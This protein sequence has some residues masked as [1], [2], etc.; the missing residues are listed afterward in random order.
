MVQVLSVYEYE[1]YKDV[2]TARQIMSWTDTASALVD[3][4]VWPQCSLRRPHKPFTSCYK[5][6]WARLRPSTDVNA[7]GVKAHAF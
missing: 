2:S 5:R 4:T 3:P 6:F 1:L 7:L